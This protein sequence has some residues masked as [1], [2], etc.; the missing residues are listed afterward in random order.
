M[1]SEAQVLA[2]LSKIIDPDFNRD[3]VSLGF[4]QDMVIDSGNI[5]FTIELT[6]PACPLRPVF[7]KQAMELV[8]AI[9][10]VEQVNVTMTSR[11]APSRQ[12]TAEKSGLK[13]VK[14]IIAVSSCKGGVGKSTVAA[15]LARTLISRGLKVGLLD[16]DVY[17]PSIPTLLMFIGLV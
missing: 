17:G 9:S 13:S 5:S 3:I 4:V 7:H 10:G 16:A 11:K 1:I 8:G 14:H 6:T 15:M 12:M 2:E